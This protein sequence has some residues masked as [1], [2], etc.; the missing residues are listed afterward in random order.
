[1][2]VDALAAEKLQ[3]QEDFAARQAEL[4]A[5]DQRDYGKDSAHPD[6]TDAEWLEYEKG[7]EDEL[8]WL[9][10]CGKG[11]GKGAKGDRRGQRKRQGQRR[12]R[13]RRARVRQGQQW[14]I[15]VHVVRGRE[16]LACTL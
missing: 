1:M 15:R 7:L 9:G 13:R 14:L 10:A 2:D 11:K 5:A 4:A 12:R 16:P 3:Q 6:Y 8:N